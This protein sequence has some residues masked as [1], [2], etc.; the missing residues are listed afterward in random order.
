M[1]NLNIAFM[2]WK[3]K[4]KKHFWDPF[5]TCLCCVNCAYNQL[6]CGVSVRAYI[7]VCAGAPGG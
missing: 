6:L 7:Y 4:K 5:I 2:K 3:G 1:T